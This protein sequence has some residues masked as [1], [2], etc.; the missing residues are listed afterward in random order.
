MSTDYKAIHK[1]NIGSYGTE[2]GR[3]GQ[4]LLADRYD[5]R[6]H[7]IF[8]LLQNAEDALAQRMDW[9]GARKAIFT[10]LNGK[11]EFSHFGKPFSEKDVRSICAIGKSEKGIS[12]IGKL[13]I[14]FKSVYAFTDMPEIHSEGEH[15]YIE[16]YVWP[17]EAGAVALEKGETRFI[18]P[19]KETDTQAIPDILRGFE[20][21]DPRIL[22]FLRQIEEISWSM[23]NGGAGYCQ[24]AKPKEVSKNG[25][26]VA[27]RGK[28]HN[29]ADEH[30]DN[31]LVFSKEVQKDGVK[32]GY[33][34]IA[35]ALKRTKDEIENW[36]IIHNLNSTLV[37]FFATVLPT[38]TGFLL[39]GPYRTTPSR[40]N[41]P[42]ND[43][44]NKEL[45]LHTASLLRQSLAELRDLKLLTPSA[46]ETLPLDDAKTTEGSLFWP[47]HTA[48]IQSFKSEA[49]IP[50]FE[51][52]FANADEVRFAQNQG[53]RELISA[54][55]LGELFAAEKLSWVSESITDDRTPNLKSFLSYD[56]KIPELRVEQ[57][58]PKLTKQF[59]EKQADN[60]IESLYTYLNGFPHQFNNAEMKNAPLV[61][62]SD[63]SH[64]KALA[65]GQPQAFF[66]TNVHTDFPTVKVEVCRSDVARKFLAQ[67]G[68]TQ[69]DPVDD[70]IRNL[71]PK[72]NSGQS[73]D[74][75]SEDMH[76]ILFAYQTDSRERRS[77]LVEALRSCPFVASVDAGT[78]QS[79]FAKPQDVYLSTPELK[80]LFEGVE[81]V[82]LI[83]EGTKVLL[84]DSFRGLLEACGA[85]RYL[86]PIETKSQITWEEER[87]LRKAEGSVGSSGGES[88]EDFTLRGLSELLSHILKLRGELAAIRSRLLWERLCDLE[89]QPKGRNAFLGTYKWFYFNPRRA[90]FDAHFL[91]QLNKSNWVLN[92]NGVLQ[93]P[94]QV[95]FEQTGWPSNAFLL[96]KVKFKPPVIDV[97]AR[98]AGIEPG[99]IDLLAEL[100]LKSEEELRKRLGIG[101]DGTSV[102]KNSQ[103]KDGAARLGVK[104]AGGNA[105]KTIDELRIAYQSSISNISNNTTPS[106]T[107]KTSSSQNQNI[108]RGESRTFSSYISV[109]HTDNDDTESMTIEERLQ[110]EELAIVR[111]LAKEPKLERTAQGNPGFDLF[112]AGSNDEIL[113][114]IEIKAMRGTLQ[115]R[116]VTLTRQQVETALQKREKYWLYIVESAGDV[117][118]A[119]VLRINNPLG[120]AKSFAFDLGWLNAAE[121]D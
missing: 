95:L 38:N 111:I 45:V 54:E 16:N 2:I 61:R 62:L 13:G 109:S 29:A 26:L 70:V 103:K 40:D 100:G 55:Q 34:E 72:Y 86:K 32:A 67:I 78:G 87:E 96:S 56:L 21:L 8:E 5:D 1:E 115:N 35:F 102:A 82:L 50:C 20:Q 69:P 99:V 98:E 66:S 48:L 112:E 85:S 15:F 60:W 37:V 49:I 58:L 105:E 22:L 91:R 30:E 19:V 39:Q 120:K 12:S 90:N 110:L 14:G 7:F 9:G 17:K 24:R 74:K 46:L 71:L 107:D 113:R 94:S 97:L 81:G 3:I 121:I 31:W 47:L 117:T 43:A 79:S 28:K 18:F 76:R 44:W 106:E 11:L 57:I 93:T 52:G 59:L 65:D 51:G 83:N 6:A 63:G 118:N 119:K 75:Y 89:M 77:K 41:I 114:Y 33:V 80:Q 23:E 53:M 10:L 92:K 68:I 88:V 101:A 42:K 73:A 108:G 36:E 25:R 64:V 84:G 4:M 27:I 104:E 116:P